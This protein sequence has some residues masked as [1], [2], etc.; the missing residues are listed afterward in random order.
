MPGPHTCLCIHLCTQD[1]L[2]EEWG[3]APEVDLVLTT[4]EILDLVLEEHRHGR[5]PTPAGSG[6]QPQLQGG[7]EGQERAALEAFWALD[8][9]ASAG[10]GEDGD[11]MDVDG[12]GAE[13]DQPPQQQR[14]AW[15]LASAE[16]ALLLSGLDPD[17]PLELLAGQVPGAEGG[18]VSGGFLEFVFR[19]AALE[20]FGVELGWE[21]PLAY[22][23][24][25]NADYQEVLLELPQPAGQP[26]G[27]AAVALRFARAYGFRNIQAVVSKLRR[28][29][30]ERAGPLHFVE[31]MACPSG[32]V[33]GGGQL[34]GPSNEPSAAGRDRVAAVRRTLEEGRRPRPLLES[35]VARWVYGPGG[36][37]PEGPLGPGAQRLF[38]TRYHAVPKL[39]MSNPSVIKW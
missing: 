32:C 34:K 2:H 16:S 17:A 36:V 20:L 29:R 33:N 8:G 18:G 37:A 14:G 7:Q 26:A 19:Y 3:E 1:F 27:E 22:Q 11:A 5:L 25:R 6:H 12:E 10:G 24:G 15:T 4:G 13:P 38:H 31:I 23:Q 35:A 30:K 21:Q 39:E 9:S 28:G